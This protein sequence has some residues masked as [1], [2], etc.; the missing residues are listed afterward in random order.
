MELL[1]LPYMDMFFEDDKDKYI[2]FYS[3]GGSYSFVQAIQE[4]GLESPF[5]KDVLKTVVHNIFL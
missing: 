2:H 4:A 1:T 3:L 5:K